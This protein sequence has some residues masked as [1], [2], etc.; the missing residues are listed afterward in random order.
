MLSI[1]DKMINAHKAGR[2]AAGKL[3][4]DEARIVR[5]GLSTQHERDAFMAGYR[6]E[7]IRQG[8]WQI[9]RNILDGRKP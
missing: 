5:D 6:G 8:T 9:A 1:E 3:N 7:A 2:A 4:I